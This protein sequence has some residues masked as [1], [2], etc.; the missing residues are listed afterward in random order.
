M[1][2]AGVP[3]MFLVSSR[4]AIGF[5]R[6]ATFLELIFFITKIKAPLDDQTRHCQAKLASQL[7]YKCLALDESSVYMLRPATVQWAQGVL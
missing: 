5:H 2:Y 4:S 6:Q 7:V 1:K 3:L